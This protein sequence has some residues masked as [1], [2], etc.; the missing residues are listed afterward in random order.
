MSSKGYHR[1]W[2]H[3]SYRASFVLRCYLAAVGAGAGLGSAIQW[4]RDHRAHHRYVDTDKDPYSAHKGLLYSHIGWAILKKD[5]KTMATSDVRDLDDDKVTA[6]QYHNICELHTICPLLC[7]LTEA[8]Y[9]L[10]LLTYGFAPAKW[11]VWLVLERFPR[12]CPV[13]R[14]MAHSIYTAW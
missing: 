10:L 8:I 3:R 12:W 7:I 1:L 14:A 11:C 13:C 4:C 9:R 2:S 6:W 5:A